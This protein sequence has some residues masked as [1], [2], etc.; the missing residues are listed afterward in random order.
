[1]VGLRGGSSAVLRCLQEMLLSAR[2]VPWVAVSEGAV[3]GWQGPENNVY[4]NLPAQYPWAPR[5]PSLAAM[6]ILIGSE[7]RTSSRSTHPW[8]NQ[9]QSKMGAWI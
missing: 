7:S 9:R 8:H 6:P 4:A 3:S 5:P 2:A 1:M